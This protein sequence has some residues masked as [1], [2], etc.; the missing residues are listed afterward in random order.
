MISK[1]RFPK[2]LKILIWNG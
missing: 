2:I 1:K